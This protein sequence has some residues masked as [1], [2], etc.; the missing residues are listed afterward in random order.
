MWFRAQS[1]DAF[2]LLRFFQAEEPPIENGKHAL[3]VAAQAGESHVAK[4][5]R[6]EEQPQF[7][8]LVRF[9]ADGQAICAAHGR[10]GGR[11]NSVEPV[12]VG[13]VPQRLARAQLDGP[14]PRE[15]AKYGRVADDERRPRGDGERITLGEVVAIILERFFD[16]CEAVSHA[17]VVVANQRLCPNRVSQRQGVAAGRVAIGLAAGKQPIAGGERGVGR[18]RPNEP[19]QPV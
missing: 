16:I 9:H 10:L 5:P 13:E 19:C 6:V 15:R 12:A 4:G 7:V 14:Q 1:L 2:V 18:G 17:E 8:L 11:Q 3:A